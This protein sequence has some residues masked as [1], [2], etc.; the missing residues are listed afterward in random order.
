MRAPRRS[1]V[2]RTVAVAAVLG[3]TLT[4]AACNQAAGGGAASSEEFPSKTVDIMVPA[5]AGG[6]WDSTAR[7]MQKVIEDED[8]VSEPVEV[9]NVEGGGGATGLSQLQKDE[10]DPHALMVTGLVMIGALEQAS[11]PVSFEDTTPIATLTSEAEAF[12]VPSDSQYESIEDVVAAYEKDPASVTFGGGSAGGSD[13][14]VVA[15]LMKAA[16]ADPSQM[17]YVGYSGGGEAI[18]GILSGDVAVGV[19][20]VSEFESQIEAG[21][22]R[23]LAISTAE[24]QEVAGEEATTLQDAGYDIDFSNWRALVAAPGLSDDAKEQV[25]EVV[26]ELHGTQGWKDALEANGWA[27]FYKT[28]DEA[29]E[30]IDSEV[31]RVAALYEDLGL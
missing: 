18:A 28:G 21:D 16:G 6:G 1:V 11:S 2:R 30:Y 3:T 29:Q 31:D 26:D 15:E 12:V 24:T 20:G 23:L 14:L 19:S 10:G 13:Q 5:A 8:V 17:K 9:F 22:M 7:A 27:D 4:L 25:T